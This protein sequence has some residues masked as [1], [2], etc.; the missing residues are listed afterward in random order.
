MIVSS[1]QV[2]LRIFIIIIQ[3]FYFKISYPNA[4]NW[5]DIVLKKKKIFQKT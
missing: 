3:S 1:F 4:E 5:S 2:H